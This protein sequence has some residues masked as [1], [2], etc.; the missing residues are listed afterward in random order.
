MGA[1]S[2][3]ALSAGASPADD[4]SAGW[5]F[6]VGS[7]AEGLLADAGAMLSTSIAVALPHRVLEPN[8]P[9]WYAR[10]INL[11]ADG[12]LE[13]NADDGAQVFVGATRLAQQRRW[14]RVP[15]H[16]SGLR[17]VIVRALNNAMAGGLRQV[18]RH[19]LSLIHI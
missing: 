4:L 15:P 9:L 10:D 19:D 11:P 13:V 12:W 3:A 8:T 1:V 7:P 18:T 5:Q 17:P 14:F 16:L 2:A 6:A